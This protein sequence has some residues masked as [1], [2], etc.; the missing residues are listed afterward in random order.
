MIS[1]TYFT[2]TD[3]RTVFQFKPA[4]PDSTLPGLRLDA[5]ARPRF[6]GA[7]ANG[8]SDAMIEYLTLQIIAALI[9]AAPAKPG[10]RN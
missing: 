1:S 8:P 3:V 9:L 2:G 4:S 5:M 6:G 7:D 10:D